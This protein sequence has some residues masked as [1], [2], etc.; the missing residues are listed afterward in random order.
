MWRLGSGT[1]H[2]PLAHDG[3]V[4]DAVADGAARASP[5]PGGF[6]ITLL[7]FLFGAS[8]IVPALGFTA[9]LLERNWRAQE[10]DVERRLEQVAADLGHDI[11]RDLTLL[12]ANLTT[13]A[14]SPDMA[15][16]DWGAVHAK[17]TQSLKPLG[18]ELLYRDRTG[19]QLVNTRVPWGTAL[20][21]SLQPEIDAAVSE[22]LKPH[23]SDIILGQVAAR[24]II[25]LTA[26]V[27]KEG[28]LTGFLH[29]SI[30]PE[31]FLTTMQGQYLPPDWITGLSDRKGSII[32][33][34]L[35]HADFVG[36]P[37]P[38]ALR[39]ENRERL[40]VF[41]TTN[42]EGVQTLRAVYRSPLTGW[43]VSANI[44]QS[45]A[46]AASFAD[47][48]WMIGI[49]A[50]LL[51][52][53]L[54]LAIL[55]GRLVAK[56]IQAIADFA[57]MVEKE[58][59][60]PPLH[61]PVREANEIAAT[62][63][64][65]A[66][67]LQDRTRTLRGTLERFNVA[68]RGADIV[69]FAQD[70]ERRLTWISET[71]GHG[72]QLIGRR[73]D[74]VLPTDAQA[75]V[76]ALE[77]RAAAS[78]QAQDGE[79]RHGRGHDARYFRLHVEPVRDAAGEVSGLLGVSSEI[80]A[81]KQSER[82]NAFLVRELAHRCK[83]MLTVVQAIATETLRGGSSLADFNERFASRVR[84]LA[85]L[86][87]LTVSGAGGDVPLHALVR[88]QL[89]PFADLA[90]DRVR[91]DGPDLRLTPEAGNSL[92]MV[93]HEL[94]TNA[95]KYGALSSE[96]G[97]IDLDWQCS[98]EG[99]PR[100]RMTWR[101]SGGPPVVPP[102]RRGFGSKV[103]GKVTAMALGGV[104]HH[105]YPAEGVIWTIDAPFQRIVEQAA[106]QPKAGAANSIKSEI[107]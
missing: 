53:A 85:K 42:V 54:L 28:A 68:L 86:Q 47:T 32:A 58:S 38:E 81:L 80:T 3:V 39:A 56:P 96:A 104:V 45:V 91:I 4:D 36:K 19:Q 77:D 79:V 25:T 27:L 9:F 64:S 5:A 88:S 65:A 48:R 100:F 13:L 50:F 46:Q 106:A 70:R 12:L 73:D 2:P 103:V 1:E 17:A 61:S 30:N 76:A 93:L 37:L 95:A 99:M 75:E 33:R 18:V 59:V 29:M 8:L 74:E 22:T 72:G 11:D 69:V 102:S 92:A 60:P 7:L 98:T 26:P 57:G 87:D 16:A 66:Q 15:A 20:P 97:R 21:R 6:S 84:S 44:P 41:R 14:A 62:L 31:R 55:L 101:E 24:P 10:A 23:I 78:G 67:R 51:V 89:E 63:R 105:D 107:G 82:R 94:A 34:L 71:A 52:L 35:R 43:L 49:G 40:G 90:Q 83:N